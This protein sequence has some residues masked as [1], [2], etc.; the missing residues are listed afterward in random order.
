MEEEC[1]ALRLAKDEAEAA[2]KISD[3]HLQEAKLEVKQLRQRC[4]EL[5]AGERP[6]TQS[7]PRFV[8]SFQ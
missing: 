7:L 1:R 2:R 5:E 8:I 3:K 4:A 6:T